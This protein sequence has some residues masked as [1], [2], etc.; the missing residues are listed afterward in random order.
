MQSASEIDT[1]LTSFLLIACAEEK[2]CTC[3]ES[4]ERISVV[5]GE[6]P[7]NVHQLSTHL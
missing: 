6:R 4:E 5:M 7:I 1:S 3:G 2:E